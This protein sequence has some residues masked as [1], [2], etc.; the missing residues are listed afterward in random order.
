MS[1]DSRA[2]APKS[3]LSAPTELPKPRGLSSFFILRPRWHARESAPLSDVSNLLSVGTPVVPQVFVSCG[4]E[5]VVF[6]AEEV[7]MFRR[8]FVDD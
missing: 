3:S 1:S 7:E 2:P 4:K 6:L 8:C 5:L